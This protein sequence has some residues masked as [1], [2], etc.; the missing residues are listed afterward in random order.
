MD[1][2]FDGLVISTE[3]PAELAAWYV[4]VFQADPHEQPAARSGALPH[5]DQSGTRHDEDRPEHQLG[6]D[7]IDLSAEH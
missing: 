7:P 4:E 3:R 5:D 6:S 1:A 2:R